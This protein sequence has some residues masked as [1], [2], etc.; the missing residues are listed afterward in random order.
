MKKILN[1]VMCSL[2]TILLSGCWDA[3]ELEG[4]YYVHAL[5]VDYVDNE[6]E[7][8][9]QI[10][11]F[12]SSP[13]TGEQQGG[14]GSG[15]EIEVGKARG[16]T[17]LEA[18][19][20]LYPSTQRRV[21]WGHLSGI[22]FTERMM[23]HGIEEVLDSIDRYREI[24][25]TLWTFTT[26]ESLHE[27]LVITPILEMNTIFSF[28]GD[29]EK[30]YQQSS[31]VE[32]I[33]EYQFLSVLREPGKTLILPHFSI[34]RSDW[35]NNLGETKEN[36]NISSASLMSDSHYK[37]VLEHNEMLGIRWIQRAAQRALLVVPD[38]EGKPLASVTL[39]TE[40][41]KIK[42]HIDEEGVT[43]SI[44]I[45]VSGDVSVLQE[46]KKLNELVQSAK[47][48]IINEV[49]E[50]YKKGLEIDADVYSFSNALYK[51]NPQEWKKLTEKNELPLTEESLQ[52]VNVKVVIDTT[53]LEKYRPP[54]AP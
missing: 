32:P 12:Q 30:S 35:K 18:I 29:P 46:D 1:L 10:V 28:L 31:L 9:L 34:T 4:M 3:E 5:G 39:N 7:V 19:H 27:L 38:S 44:D 13:G 16:K 54:G 15:S 52:E 33:Q 6:Y 26:S 42:P 49:E 14:G 50:T 48:Q 36:L 51:E 21:F 25:P 37:G 47:E 23:E 17:A 11:N 8:Y 45:K 41:V 2:L 43:F 53:G 24:K 22:V 40:K 20:H